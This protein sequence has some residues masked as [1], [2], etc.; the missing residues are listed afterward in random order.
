MRFLTM[1]HFDKCGFV[2][3]L[4]FF[5]EHVLEFYFPNQFLRFAPHYYLQSK[6]ING[7]VTYKRI[8]VTDAEWTENLQKMFIR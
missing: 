3:L 8:K 6:P 5:Y 4:L 2:S 1:W 7:A